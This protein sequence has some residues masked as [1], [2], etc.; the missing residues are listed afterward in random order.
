MFGFMGYTAWF[1]NEDIDELSKKQQKQ[2]QLEKAGALMRFINKVSKGIAVAFLSGG[3]LL[4][5][6]WILRNC[7]TIRR[8]ILRKGGKHVT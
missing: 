2:E 5:T 4:S 1:L 7:H 3:S 8:L 6:Y